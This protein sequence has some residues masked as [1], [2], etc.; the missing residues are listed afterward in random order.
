MANKYMLQETSNP[1]ILANTLELHKHANFC[2]F[3][4]LSFSNRI[5]QRVS[6]KH[7]GRRRVAHWA[8]ATKNVKKP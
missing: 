3:P 7:A 6:D 8:R 1:N 4:L 2:L 5:S